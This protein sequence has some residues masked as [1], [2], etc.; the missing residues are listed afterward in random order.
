MAPILL[1]FT[2]KI[3]FV[4][5]TASPKKHPDNSAL[6]INLPRFHQCFDTDSWVTG[7]ASDV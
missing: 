5:Q 4:Y 3:Q 6:V 2:G 7:K 1:P